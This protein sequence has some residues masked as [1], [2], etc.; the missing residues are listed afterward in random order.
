MIELCQSW[1]LEDVEPPGDTG[2]SP[3]RENAP[4]HGWPRI[5]NESGMKSRHQST[6]KNL[7]IDETHKSEGERRAPQPRCCKS[8]RRTI[9]QVVQRDPQHRA[10]EQH[11]GAEM[12]G[13]T[14][15]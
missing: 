1:I 2:E 9:A 10:K 7:D 5:V 12:N 6:E 15:L 13:K 4:I 8:A 3:F 11:C 14:V